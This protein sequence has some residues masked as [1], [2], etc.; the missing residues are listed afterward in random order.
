MSSH[1]WV[2]CNI[3]YHLLSK[4]TR[5]FFLMSCQH[6]LCKDC[7]AQSNR[8]TCC[9]VC[10]RQGLQFVEICN[11]MDKKFKAL[12][13]PDVPKTVEQSCKIINFQTKQKQH[14]IDYLA[15]MDE[16]LLK[17]EQMEHRIKE[18]ICE[19]QK[20]YH[21][22]R[23]YRRNQQQILRQQ[24][25]LAE[26]EEADT[27]TLGPDPAASGSNN[28]PSSK[29]NQ[30]SFFDEH[31]RK[32]G[33]KDSRLSASNTLSVDSF[34]NL[35]GSTSSDSSVRSVDFGTTPSSGDRSTGR[36][37]ETFH[38]MRIDEK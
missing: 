7:M 27:P 36:I 35:K 33:S 28:V 19:L 1:K 20:V 3:C 26:E 10:K 24:M 37:H 13:D 15:Y 16:K 23:S 18:K 17:A 11:T 22:T 21:K 2:H 14:L 32:S 9:P 31:S 8:G 5:R 34:M 6:T 4:K 30:G 12:F 25:S 38:R 29:R